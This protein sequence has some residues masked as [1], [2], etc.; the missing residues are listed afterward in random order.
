M[1]LRFWPGFSLTPDDLV[2][3]HTAVSINRRDDS[4]VAKELVESSGERSRSSCFSG[5]DIVCR[6]PR[7][8][9]HTPSV[10]V[11]AVG[12]TTAV[13]SRPVQIC[14]RGGGGGGRLDAPGQHVRME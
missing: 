4:G 1:E 8:H 11:V 7:R 9:Q 2:A 13:T 5:S 3:R 14:R 6:W 12:K 10:A